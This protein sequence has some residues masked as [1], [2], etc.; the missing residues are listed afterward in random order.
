MPFSK[1]TGVRES[2]QYCS[3]C[4]HGGKL[5]YGGDLKGFQNVCYE[6]MIKSGMNKWQAKL[7]AWMIQ[8]AP[9]WKR[10]K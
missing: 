10:G 6:N 8:F 3:L 2:D 7:Y 4:F 5:C 1:D 9:R